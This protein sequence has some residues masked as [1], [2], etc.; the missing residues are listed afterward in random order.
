MQEGDLELVVFRDEQDRKKKVGPF[1]K[2]VDTILRSKFIREEA[3]ELVHYKIVCVVR[4][5]ARIVLVGTKEELPLGDNAR[6]IMFVRSYFY[7]M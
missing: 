1:D 7:V 3:L 4:G 6:H 5:K 2:L